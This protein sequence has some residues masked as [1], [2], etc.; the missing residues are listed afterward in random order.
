ME[1]WVKRLDDHSMTYKITYKEDLSD[2]YKGN[3][4]SKWKS[5]VDLVDKQESEMLMKKL[6][7]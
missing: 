4:F 2:V 6:K 1:T 3:D 7:C 5:E